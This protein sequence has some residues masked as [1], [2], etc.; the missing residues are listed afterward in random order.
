M[1]N[2]ELVISGLFTFDEENIVDS[3]E[4]IAFVIYHGFFFCKSSMAHDK[5]IF[6]LWITGSSKQ[7][8]EFVLIER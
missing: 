6:V 1:L 7:Q 2:E 3:L 8:T 5:H 4:A